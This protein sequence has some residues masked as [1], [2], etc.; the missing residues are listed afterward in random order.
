MRSLFLAF[1]IVLVPCLAQ[2]KEGDQLP[3]L[4]TTPYMIIYGSQ[5]CPTTVRFVKTMRSWGV[6]FVY[7][8]VNMG[9][10]QKE[11]INRT[12]LAGIKRLA[13][14]TVDINGQIFVS[15]PPETAYKLYMAKVPPKG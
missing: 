7:R 14:P 12:T 1:L 8:N 4:Y 3:L 13:V 5:S 9:P 10:A 6:P 11:F 15:P 2:A